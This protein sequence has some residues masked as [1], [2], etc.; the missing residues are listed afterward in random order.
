MPRLSG[1]QT[2]KALPGGGEDLPVLVLTGMLDEAYIVAA[3]DAGADDYVTKPFQPRVLIARL[4]ALLRRQPTTQLDGDGGG[5]R[6]G[7]VLLDAR[8]HEALVGDEHIALSPIEYQLMRVLMR[9]A[10]RVFTTDELLARV[11]GPAYAGED[12]IVRRNI[13]RL[14][15]KL[16]PRPREPRYILGRRGV[17]YQFVAE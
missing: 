15:Q 10:G 16:E 17:G 12:D 8:T 1:L 3:F 7:D 5:M 4:K 2:L 14:R 11:W 13:Y 6:V 9:Q